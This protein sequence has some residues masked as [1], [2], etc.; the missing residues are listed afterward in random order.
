[1]ADIPTIHE[2]LVAVMDDVSAVRKDQRNRQQNYSFRGIDAVVNAVGPSFR[3]H[4][5]VCVPFVED[6]RFETYQ[7]SSGT[8]MRNCVV[9]MRYVFHGPGG[10]TYEAVVYGE[11]SDAGDKSVSKAQ[12]VA[13][14]VALLQALTIP[15]DEPDPDSDSHSRAG[16]QPA[17]RRESGRGGESV[18]PPPP[19]PPAPKD[20][21]DAL[22]YAHPD[23][24][25]K[26]IQWRERKGLRSAGDLTPEQ[27]KEALV[28]AKSLLEGAST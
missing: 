8:T 19:A 28:Y 11:A 23:I 13:Y 22:V 3:T 14:R 26:M 5:V 24:R 15:T 9:K 21:L 6:V 17:S 16:S 2:A 1:M 4:K 10:D 7:T 20:E 27:R 18:S 25:A 12:S